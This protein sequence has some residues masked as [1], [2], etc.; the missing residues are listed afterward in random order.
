MSDAPAATPTAPR[1]TRALIAVG[2][3]A[4]AIVAI[5]VLGVVLSENVVYFRPVSEALARRESD[6][7]TRFRIAG[8]VV[9]GSVVE[10]RDGVRFR[11]TDGEATATIAH[12]GDPPSLFKDGAPVV[13]EGRWSGK[14]FA[15]DRILIRHGNEYEPPAVDGNGTKSSGAKAQ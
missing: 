11:I 8:E 12:R 13:C 10:T 5:V 14:T 15:S 6:G 7:T 1:R 9:D 4:F 3:C 2:L